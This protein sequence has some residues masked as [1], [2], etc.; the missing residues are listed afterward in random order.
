MPPIRVSASRTC[1]L[2]R[3][4]LALVVEILEAAAA[5][6]RVMGARRL[7][8]L[9][10]RLEHL[11]RERLGEAAL[12]LRHPRTHPVARKPAADED[13]E[14]VQARDAVAAVRERV[15]LQLE[16]VVPL[17]RRGHRS[18]GS[19]ASLRVAARHRNGAEHRQ[20]DR[21]AERQ[22]GRGPAAKRELVALAPDDARQRGTGQVLGDRIGVAD[23]REDEP[24]QYG[25]ERF[26]DEESR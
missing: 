14:A 10:R 4:D 26:D 8:A 15:D 6:R 3:R 12:D 21:V 20:A 2:L 16:L 22:Q 24:R 5:A 7:D 1:V 25:D 11:R 23:V 13:D 9:R 17:H 18:E 19:C